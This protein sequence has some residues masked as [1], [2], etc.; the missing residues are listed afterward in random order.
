MKS[1]IHLLPVDIGMIRKAMES[2]G[3][4]LQGFEKRLFDIPFQKVKKAHNGVVRLD[5]MEM[6]LIVQALNKYGKS[7]QS[8]GDNEQADFY[9][10]LAVIVNEFKSLYQRQN[11][12]K[13][14]EITA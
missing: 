14:K 4:H 9:F 6:T 12:P 1:K 3:R 7:Y 11:G 13:I 2:H 10:E 5:D 8:A